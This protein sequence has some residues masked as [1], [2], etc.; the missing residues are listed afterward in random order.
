MC[1][2]TSFNPVV[3]RG[4]A[5]AG[6]SAGP[7]PGTVDLTVCLS[8]LSPSG[9]VSTCRNRYQNKK[10]ALHPRVMREVRALATLSPLLSP[11]QAVL[12][13][14]NLDPPAHSWPLA[15]SRRWRSPVIGLRRQPEFLTHTP[16]CHWAIGKPSRDFPCNRDEMQPVLP[17]RSLWKK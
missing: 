7:D 6:P 16:S 1:A 3:P 15:A 17:R 5:A 12:S 2:L 9:A 13:R 11:L 4:F 10:R 14:R 8:C